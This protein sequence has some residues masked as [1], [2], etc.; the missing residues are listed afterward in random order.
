M[1]GG[2]VTI[3]S[4][5]IGSVPVEPGVGLGL[6]IL[7]ALV[8]AHDHGRGV[9]PAA[10][11]AF[12][13]PLEA[14]IAGLRQMPGVDLYTSTVVDFGRL[15]LLSGVAA[16]SHVHL[17]GG[18]AT[19][20]EAEVIARAACDVGVRV[21]YALPVVDANAIAYGGPQVFCGCHRPD[22]WQIVKD[23]DGRPV[24]AATQ[25]Q[26]MEAVACACESPTFTVQYGPAGPQ[27]VSE[28]G[29]ALPFAWGGSG[30]RTG[31]YPQP[32]RRKSDAD[33]PGR[34]WTSGQRWSN[35]ARPPWHKQQRLSVRHPDQSGIPISPASRSVRHPGLPVAEFGP[36]SVG[37]CPK[38]RHLAPRDCC[39]TEPH[40]PSHHFYRAGRACQGDMAGL[41][42]VLH[43][44]QGRHPAAGDAGP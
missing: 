15:A 10:Y 38:S 22:D 43:V 36:K 27:W 1:P 16:V 23:W 29:L 13:Q 35:P 31:G 40:A 20:A 24:D 39:I 14:W 8:N 34:S 18:G 6:A 9:R 32:A 26:A 11:G 3:K 25:M 33:H 30:A 17:P 44:L 12:E 21:A 42:V 4:Q 7:P 2:R 5:H 19:L 37:L 41:R 28:A